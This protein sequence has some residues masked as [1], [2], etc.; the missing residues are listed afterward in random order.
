MI[1][2]EKINFKSNYSVHGYLYL[3]VNYV[4]LIDVRRIIPVFDVNAH[5]SNEAG[6]GCVVTNSSDGL[7]W[8]RNRALI[9]WSVVKQ[10]WLDNSND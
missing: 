3:D 8:F 10:L 5:K 9:S 2:L 4:S 1:G 7:R 6:G